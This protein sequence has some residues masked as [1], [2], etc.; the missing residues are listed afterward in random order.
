MSVAKLK[1]KSQQRTKALTTI[2]GVVVI[3]MSNRIKESHRRNSSNSG[4]RIPISPLPRCKLKS[5]HRSLASLFVY[6]EQLRYFGIA[7]S[8]VSVRHGYTPVLVVVI[9][10][11]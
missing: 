1:S 8:C 5:V 9:A 10:S 4:S 3:T 11:S 7:S 2:K 6:G